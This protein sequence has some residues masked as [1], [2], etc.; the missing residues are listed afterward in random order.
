MK[1]TGIVRR[2]DDLGRVVI[3]KEIRRTMHIADGDPLEIF[4]DGD[5][6][7]TF[8]KYVSEDA[9]ISKITTGM[10][11]MAKLI[12][13]PVILCKADREIYACGSFNAAGMDMSSN[14]VMSRKIETAVYTAM[15]CAE[16]KVVCFDGP[17][18]PAL[19]G[20]SAERFRAL[21][22]GTISYGGDYVG[23]VICGGSGHLALTDNELKIFRLS[24][25]MLTQ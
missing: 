19:M 13:R 24:V 16:G 10:M 18:L 2:I 12:S 20:M 7:I 25:K 5:G 14:K 6:G 8:K 9:R 17:P 21:A 4:V 1:A 22:A 23:V 15:E 3:P 11:E